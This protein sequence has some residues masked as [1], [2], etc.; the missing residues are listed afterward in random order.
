MKTAAVSEL[1]AR[2]S[3]Y[4]DR[5]KAGEPAYMIFRTGA[6]GFREPTS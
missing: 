3:K 5:V 6:K 2:L 4:L 1:K